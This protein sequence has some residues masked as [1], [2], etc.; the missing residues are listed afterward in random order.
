[1]ALPNRAQ[2]ESLNRALLFRRSNVD[3]IIFLTDNSLFRN[4]AP[5][6]L[7]VCS[8]QY[9]MMTNLLRDTM[10]RNRVLLHWDGL[11]TLCDPFHQDGFIE[12]DAGIA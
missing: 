2:K 3:F 10:Y 11:Q 1:M 4:Q 12:K 9:C 7:I 8:A 6:F 5:P